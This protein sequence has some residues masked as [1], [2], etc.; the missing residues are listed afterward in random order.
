MDDIE[1]YCFHISRSQG[2]P[3]F[4]AS[5]GNYD[6]M[7]IESICTVKLAFYSNSKSNLDAPGWCHLIL[8]SDKCLTRILL[9]TRENFGFRGSVHGD[10]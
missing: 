3:D 4:R 9:S 7:L 5:R 10:P 6:T 2:M 8:F 1:N